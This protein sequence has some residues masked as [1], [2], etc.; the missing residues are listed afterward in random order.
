MTNSAV[1]PVVAGIETAPVNPLRTRRFAEGCGSLARNDRVDARMPAVYGQFRDLRETKPASDKINEISDL[2]TTLRQCVGQR[3][4]VRK[5]GGEVCDAARDVSRALIADLDRHIEDLEEHIAGCIASDEGLR[6]RDAVIESV[7]G[8][9]AALC[10]DMPEPGTLSR[11]RA[12]AL[13]G[14]ASYDNE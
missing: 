14:V 9:S 5:L 4:A 7:P 12:T 2:V 1:T 10:A 6:R 13:L 8:C 11:S 3:D